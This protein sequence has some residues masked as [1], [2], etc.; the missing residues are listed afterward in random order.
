MTLTIKTM[1]LCINYVGSVLI[2]YGV[3][4]ALLQIFRSLAQVFM[5]SSCPLSWLSNM[6]HSNSSGC[7]GLFRFSCHAHVNSFSFQLF[8]VLGHLL[9]TP[10]LIYSFVGFKLSSWKASDFLGT[11]S[12]IEMVCCWEKEALL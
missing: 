9:T 6:V 2:A 3:I 1:K 7:K 8:H 10:S 11:A 12:C 4:A 5:S